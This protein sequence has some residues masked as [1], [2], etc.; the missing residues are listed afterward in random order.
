M[1]KIILFIIATGFAIMNCM[2]QQKYI[3]DALS[4]GKN[5]FYIYG[6]KL[7]AS[8]KYSNPEALH[9]KDLLNWFEN[10]Q[11]FLLV[12][13]ENDSFRLG[14]VYYNMV[15]EFYFLQ[16]NDIQLS[17][18]AIK[19]AVKEKKEADEIATAFGTVTLGALLGYVGN[20]IERNIKDTRDILSTPR[21]EIYYSSNNENNP[22]FEFLSEEYH[23]I[24]VEGWNSPYDAA[25]YI[26][27]DG[28][29]IDICEE[30]F[31][32]K[33]YNKNGIIYST[34]KWRVGGPGAEF[35]IS[36]GN[37]NFP[38]IIE[39][40]YKSSCNDRDYKKNKIKIKKGGIFSITLKS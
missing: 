20:A 18:D 19:K 4:I 33:C 35:K 36:N 16:K 31:S 24:K 25:I 2:A 23:E 17:K 21:G 1:K 30:T 22:Y 34:N 12:H 3:N 38:A 26:Y 32:L 5:K 9:L 39:I 7:K 8:N 11:D 14:K 29:L 28:F 13:Y 27:D 15:T 40:L 10:N 37:Y 6:K